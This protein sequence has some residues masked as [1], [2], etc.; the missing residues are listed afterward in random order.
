MALRLVCTKRCQNTKANLAPLERS[1]VSR[2]AQTRY[3]HCIYHHLSAVFS[4]NA[5]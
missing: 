2:E 4:Q 3:H 5:S 1:P